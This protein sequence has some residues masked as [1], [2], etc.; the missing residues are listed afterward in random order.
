[1]PSEKNVYISAFPDASED[2]A[3]RAL[4]Q[5]LTGHGRAGLVSRACNLSVGTWR[6]TR[7]ILRMT[8][9]SFLNNHDAEALV[10]L[11]FLV[12]AK[13]NMDH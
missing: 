7:A 13:S 10:V 11:V 3:I 2:R 12:D 5:L 6:E 9:H 8:R 1:M 4:D